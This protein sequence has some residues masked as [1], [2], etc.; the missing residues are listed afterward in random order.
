MPFFLDIAVYIYIYTHT[1]STGATPYKLVQR[2]IGLNLNFF[3]QLISV[4]LGRKN[5]EP[6]RLIFGGK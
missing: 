1:A 3:A 2:R 4:L 5:E 6:V